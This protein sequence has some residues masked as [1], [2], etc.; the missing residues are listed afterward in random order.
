MK[1]QI[2]SNFPVEYFTEK[3]L[4]FKKDNQINRLDTLY[5]ILNEFTRNNRNS[6][7]F[8][9]VPLNN[10]ACRAV[11]SKNFDNVKNDL[12]AFDDNGDT[13][14]TNESYDPGFRSMWYKLGFK[15]CY[16]K[17]KEV[18]L[19][20]NERLKKY[21]CY[22]AGDRAYRKEIQIIEPKLH[23][24]R[25][26]NDLKIT[27]DASVYEFKKLFIYKFV[28]L[29]RSENNIK[30]K[31]L[32]YAEVG[33]IIDDINRLTNPKRYTYT[34]SKKNLRFNSIFTNIK[35]ELRF[36]IRHNGNKF[37]EFD[38]IASHS[39]I[40]A[41]ILNEEFFF[42][43]KEYSMSNIYPDLQHRINSYID[44][45]YKY[46][47]NVEVTQAQEVASRRIYHHMSDSFF[48]K[49]DI[50]LYKSI[51]F[52][53]DFYGFIAAIF[54]KINPDLQ[55]LSRN[56]VKSIIRLW[57][58]HNDPHE[59]KR[60][61]SLKVLKRIFPSIDLLIEEIGF[62]NTM[63]SAFS[64]LL[65]RSESHLVLDVVGKKLVEDYPSTRL[66]TIHD[67]F[68]IE[69]TDINKNEIIAKIKSILTEYVGII[70]GIKLKESSPFDSLDNII[71][72]DVVEIRA[73]ALKKESKKIGTNERVFSPR[74]IKYVEMG[75]IELW[76]K[77]GE[78]NLQ[79]EFET[80]I[81]NLYPE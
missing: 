51:D 77:Y 1:L 9:G 54:N 12:L 4:A 11:C 35:R 31:F 15:Y 37:L 21:K 52:E 80:F 22:L 23:L 41:T 34:L 28:E 38:L 56:E 66:F 5:I 42:S 25:Q 27:L 43:N 70:P 46:N 74:T 50:E 29:I 49:F 62:F 59:R 7:W 44:A 78:D 75:N 33:K 64:L 3:W 57:M 2:P 6:G 69:D 36:F 45:A 61:A 10:E 63:K 53:A 73:K 40:L 47:S 81:L 30:I 67:S 19:S 14:S 39:Y 32:Y 79:E 16:T 8:T 76:S 26:F 65:Q 48:E 20:S 55:Q 17:T 24:E 58:N 68:F 72:E 60:V 13:F 71:D 18:T